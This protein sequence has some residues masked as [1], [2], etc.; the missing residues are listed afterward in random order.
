MKKEI[1]KL[2]IGSSGVIVMCTGE[3][4]FPEGDFAGVIVEQ[5]NHLSP[6]GTYS[7]TWSLPAFTEHNEPVVLNNEEQLTAVKF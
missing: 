4:K 2:Y 3:G 6:K 1:G 7:N 5:N